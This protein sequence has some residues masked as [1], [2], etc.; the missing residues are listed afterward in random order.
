MIIDESAKSINLGE[1]SNLLSDY[2]KL[3]LLA[4]QYL[5][6]RNYN[7]AKKSFKE[8]INL[9]KQMNDFDEIKHAESLA[10]YGICQYFCGKFTESFSTLESAFQISSRLI[11]HL[12]YS[13]RSIKK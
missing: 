9:I 13:D 12:L 6:N 11:E 1:R 5:R 3:N 2:V 7:S 8:C 10:N 4:F